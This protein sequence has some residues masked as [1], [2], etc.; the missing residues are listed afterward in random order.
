MR[1]SRKN[2]STMSRPQLSFDDRLDDR[3]RC[4]PGA[5]TTSWHA[6]EVDLDTL[7]TEPTDRPTVSGAAPGEVKIAARDASAPAK[8]TPIT[9]VTMDRFMV[10]TDRQP[11]DPP[12][13]IEVWFADS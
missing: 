6:P 9:F 7:F 11:V 10:G 2:V 8:D 12:E 1:K 4:V 3:P 13:F 5:T